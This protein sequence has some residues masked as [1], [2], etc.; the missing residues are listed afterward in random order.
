MLRTVEYRR[1]TVGDWRLVVLPDLWES[2]LQSE[3]LQAAQKQIWSKHP[4]TVEFR[5]SMR[6]HEKRYF[7]KVFHRPAGGAAVKDIFRKSKAMRFWEQGMALTQAGFHVPV[8]I[9][10]GEQ[11][12]VRVANLAFILTEKIEGSPLPLFLH[13][14]S[15]GPVKTKD[16]LKA[17]RRALTQLATLVGQ[18]H[19]LGFVHG[20]MVASNLMVSG[21]GVD[22]LSYYFMDNDR[23]R[24]YPA[25]MPQ[26]FWKR[27]LIQLNR[28]P[29]PGITLQDRMRFF[30]AYL[31]KAKL[32]LKKERKFL[33]WLEV[34]T[35]QR[36]KECDGVDRNVSF[37]NLMRWDG[38]VA[39]DALPQVARV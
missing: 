39:Q 30:T 9:A 38:S 23:T 2:T 17:K 7:L 34:R 11:R 1:M 15:M 18:F 4:Q 32:D 21:P 31:G 28:M 12:H 5:W 16:E 19:R 29:L 26:P 27:N 13:N 8:T 22:D 24:R 20:D 14:W 25:W 37:R 10:A 33:S 35:R 3:V 36:R 6:G